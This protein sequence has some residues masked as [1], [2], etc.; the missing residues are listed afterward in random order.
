MSMTCAEP[1]VAEDGVGISQLHQILLHCL[2]LLR[3]CTSQLRL[4]RMR[5][6]YLQTSG[7]GPARDSCS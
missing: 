1:Q 7:K 3:P 4:L 5:I 2:A 6:I